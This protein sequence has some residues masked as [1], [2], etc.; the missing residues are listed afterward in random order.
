MYNVFDDELLS[1]EWC[2]QV[3]EGRNKEYGAYRLRST[4]GWR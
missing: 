3:F 2:E 4:A 1:Q